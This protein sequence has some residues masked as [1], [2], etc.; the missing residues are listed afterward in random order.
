MALP[1]TSKPVGAHS[2]DKLAED[3]DSARKRTEE[4]TASEGIKEGMREGVALLLKS[5]GS[6][7]TGGE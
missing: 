4:D 6:H 3:K 7:L 1:V 5:R 2:D